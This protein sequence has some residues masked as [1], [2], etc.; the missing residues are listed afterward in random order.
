MPGQYS[1]VLYCAYASFV[2]KTSLAEL[3]LRR[4]QMLEKS[5][6]STSLVFIAQFPPLLSHL[7]FK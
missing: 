1:D 7:L 4:E 5:A 3:A 6:A 2:S